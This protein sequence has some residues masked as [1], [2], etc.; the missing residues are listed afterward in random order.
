MIPASL[1]LL[2]AALA[3]T[4]AFFQ[5]ASA[6]DSKVPA[7]IWGDDDAGSSP[8]RAVVLA[9]F[10]DA[11]VSVSVLSSAGE[12]AVRADDSLV[13]VAEPSVEDAAGPFTNYT[14]QFSFTG[15]VGKAA[16]SFS[17]DDHTLSG[18]FVVAGFVIKNAGQIVSGDDGK[19][20]T[21]GQEGSFSFQVDAV[22]VDGQSVDLSSTAIELRA[23]TGVY[24]EEVDKSKTGFSGDKF[25]IA[26]NK[27]RVGSG[28]FLISFEATA[29]EYRGEIFE[30]VLHVEQT[31]TPEPPCVVDGASLLSK[32]GV[33][34]AAMYNLLT[35]PKS[36]PVKDIVLSVGGQS[37]AFATGASMLKLPTSKVVFEG[38]SG[39]GPA[40]I[41]CDGEAAVVVE[42][43]KEVADGLVVVSGG[44]PAPLA[45]DEL[46]SDYPTSDTESL[47][48]SIVR[49]V[50]GS[51][52]T[53]TVPE[54]QAILEEYK[55]V[56]KASSVNIK[57]IIE[58]SAIMDMG[59]LVSDVDTASDALK[60]SFASCT[61]QT[62]T[63]YACNKLEL[64]EVKVANAVGVAATTATAGIAT[65][66]IVLIAVVGA[67]GLVA[68]ISLTVWAVHRRAALRHDES[69]YSSS[70]PLG[71]PDPSD[72][73]YE[74]SIVRD[75]YGRGEDGGPSAQAADAAETM[76]ARREEFPRPPSS[77]GLSRGNGSS[78]ASST[79]S[80]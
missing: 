16:Y 52:K 72:L 26:I 63:G 74:Q 19:G 34:E 39:V 77:S 28:A 46:L 59:G 68:L 3:L 9:S 65:W 32:G 35:P 29:I 54:A 30:T 7:L 49:I 57:S 27:L 31:T 78:D 5:P 45:I 58:G 13:S 55:K 64:G 12:P 53:F 76:A 37:I 18:S 20:V 15:D 73:L 61:F 47:I 70:G 23:D 22:G 24:M 2:A 69:S 38:V 50:D 43:G 8:R 44:P 60:N 25:T 56:L 41:T 67:I 42:D 10:G 80:V 36:T 75:I 21:V 33:V 6:A 17:A 79:Y 62:N 40:E 48:T 14:Y 1:L 51:P 71:V 66:T 11:V 4:L